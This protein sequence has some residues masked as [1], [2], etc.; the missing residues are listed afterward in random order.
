MSFYDDFEN[1]CVAWCRHDLGLR[2]SLAKEIEEQM[3][4]V[5]QLPDVSA[6]S[7]AFINGTWHGDLHIYKD[8][9]GGNGRKG[10]SGKNIH[11]KI[12]IIPSANV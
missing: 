5:T 2:N 6:Q 4:I 1:L 11:Y 7:R 10:V 12:L 9:G 8:R 3:S